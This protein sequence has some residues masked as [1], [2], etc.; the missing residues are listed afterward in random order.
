LAA[1]H[2]L[3]TF[4]WRAGCSAL[5]ILLHSLGR[6]GLSRIFGTSRNRRHRAGKLIMTAVL[7]L[8]SGVTRHKL[9]VDDYY[10]MAETGILKR[11]DRVELIDGEIIDMAPIGS[12]HAG[13]TIGLNRIFASA[14]VEGLALV[15]VQNPLRLDT[16]N[17]L[18]PD[19]ILLRPRKDEYRSSH[20]TPA[21]VLLLV[22]VSDSSLAYDRG[23]KLTLYARHKVPEVWIVNIPAKLIEVYRN[24]I[25]N[26]FG[27]KQEFKEGFIAPELLPSLIVNLEQL[28]G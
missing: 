24:P 21:D 28:L 17:E 20:P 4:A 13:N 25:D 22:E 14:V 7:D 26:A 18:Q 19:F 15:S 16:H 11:E 1:W 23:A 8:P 27:S 5:E 9:T 2:R 6:L 10:R 12:G 3:R